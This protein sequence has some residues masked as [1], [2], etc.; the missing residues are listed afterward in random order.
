[1]SLAKPIPH[2][3]KVERFLSMIRVENECW[4]YTGHIA[5][6]GYGVIS[7]SGDKYKAHRIAYSI[8]KTH[9]KTNL[10]LDHTCR[11]RSCV[12]PEHLREV[13]SKINILENSEGVASKNKNKTHC[14]SGHSYEGNLY[15]SK[16][17]RECKKC[18]LLR[19]KIRRLSHG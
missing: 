3:V 7:F 16:G 6:D 1:M 9:P 4:K 18:N 13:T 12:N 17:K 8:F 15:T 11:N 19:G 5:K 2:I 10:V 14:N